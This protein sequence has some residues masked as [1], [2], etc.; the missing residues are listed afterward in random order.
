MDIF[1]V[2]V[3]IIGCIC[4]IVAMLIAMDRPTGGPLP[5][6]SLRSLFVITAIIAGFSY[7]VCRLQ[8]EYYVDVHELND[9]LAEHAEIDRVW[10]CTN[11]D[12]YLEVEVV[13]FSIKGDANLTYSCR[14]PDGL[15]ISEFRKHFERAL[16]E[17]VPVVLPLGWAI[18]HQFR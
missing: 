7:A 15:Q 3:A 16:Q 2:F 6:F 4:T 18:E 8:K 13:Y 11:P 12:V 14:G 10:I 9:V 1:A 5:R 17:R